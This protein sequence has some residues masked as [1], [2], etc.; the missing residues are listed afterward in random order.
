MTEVLVKGSVLLF[1][2]ALLSAAT[3]SSPG[4]QA[5]ESAKVDTYVR[6]EMQ[7]ERIPGLTL[8]VYREGRIV[9]AEGY[10]WRMSSGMCS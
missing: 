8:G 5:D 9:K 4:A 1:C 2:A 7:K 6:G 10:G 3:A